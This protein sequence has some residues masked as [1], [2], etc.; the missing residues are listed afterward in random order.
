MI[1]SVTTVDLFWKLHRDSSD[2]FSDLTNKHK[3]TNKKQNVTRHKVLLL[4]LL[5]VVQQRL[6]WL[7]YSSDHSS[8]W[9][10]GD[11]WELTENTDS[12]DWWHLGTDREHRQRRLVIAGN[13][14]R[15][16][17]A[18]TGDSWELTENTDRQRRLVI[19]GNWQRTQTAT[20]VCQAHEWWVPVSRRH[21][22][23][24]TRYKCHSTTAHRHTHGLVC[25]ESDV[26]LQSRNVR[27]LMPLDPA[28]S[29]HHQHI[30]ADTVCS[31]SWTKLATRQL[32][33][34]H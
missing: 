9:M 8:L 1:R 17:T 16:Q 12:D 26:A 24:Q 28:H 3:Q 19:A 5:R 27:H 30:T 32:F 13:W 18:T 2:C 11:I 7:K 20:H 31:M 34:A 22:D 15:T 6:V 14:K 4:L 10:T 21:P 29:V 33:T 25:S 23:N